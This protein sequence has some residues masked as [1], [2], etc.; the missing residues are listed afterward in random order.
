MFP[1]LK[2]CRDGN[3]S[4]THDAAYGLKTSP[5]DS[6]ALALRFRFGGGGCF[7]R[8]AV[9]LSL[10][11]GLANLVIQRFRTLV[12]AQAI[13]RAGAQLPASQFAP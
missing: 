5:R 13:K 1:R 6:R 7:E 12:M 9:R 3:G 8:T 2:R 11:T 4:V 10:S